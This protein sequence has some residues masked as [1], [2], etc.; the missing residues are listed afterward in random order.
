[1]SFEPQADNYWLSRFIIS[2]KKMAG[3]N[4][5]HFFMPEVIELRSS[6]RLTM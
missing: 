2:D 4:A 5:C 1:M 6:S 3:R